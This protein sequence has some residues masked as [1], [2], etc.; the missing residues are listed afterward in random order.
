MAGRSFDVR[1]EGLVHGA[2]GSDDDPFVKEAGATA[3]ENFYNAFIGNQPRRRPMPEKDASPGPSTRYT[4]SVPMHSTPIRS[5]ATSSKHVLSTKGK[6]RRVDIQTP[7]VKRSRGRPRKYPIHEP[8]DLSS[9]SSTI[10]KDAEHIFE[11][12]TRIAEKLQTLDSPF[13]QLENTDQSVR[14]THNAASRSS[15]VILSHDNEPNNQSISKRKRGRPRKYPIDPNKEALKAATKAA[16]SITPWR[17][18]EGTDR[19]PVY[20]ETHVMIPIRR[21]PMRSLWDSPVKIKPVPR[22]SWMYYERPLRADLEPKRSDGLKP[23]PLPTAPPG[24]RGRTR[25]NYAELAHWQLV[26]RARR[27]QLDPQYL[28]AACLQRWKKGGQSHAWHAKRD[29]DLDAASKR[30]SHG[31]NNIQAEKSLSTIIGTQDEVKPVRDAQQFESFNDPSQIIHEIGSEDSSEG[32]E[33]AE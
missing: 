3:F 4:G 15:D 9:Y 10:E 8:R 13:V 31:V 12:E 23:E 22:P 32:Y 6:E 27:N 7:A 14:A 28:W 17:R 16:A 5:S 26:C 24:R 29:K 21:M 2:R 25:V 30:G 11:R 20:P 1:H 19:P 33:T 18:V